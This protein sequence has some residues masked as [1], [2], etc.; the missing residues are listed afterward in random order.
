MGQTEKKKKKGVQ[1]SKS[2]KSVKQKYKP[3]KTFSGVMYIL[4]ILQIITAV[5]FFIYFYEMNMWPVKYLLYVSVA[6]AVVFLIAMILKR[7]KWGC[8]VSLL[9]TIV[10]IVVQC[11]GIYFINITN[12]TIGEITDKANTDTNVIC[13]LVLDENK[14]KTIQD[15]KEYNFGILKDLER[16][17]TDET[18]KKINSEVGTEIETTE[19][20][21]LLNLAAALY[22]KKVDAIIIN[23]AYVEIIQEFE[24]YQNFE[25][26]I[27]SIYANVITERKEPEETKKTETKQFDIT[28]DAFNVYVSGIDVSG[29]VTTKSRSDVNIIMSINPSTKQILLLSTPRDY[30]L[31][32]S[33]SSGVKDKLTH[34][35]LYGVDVSIETLEMLYGIDIDYYVRM[36]FTGFTDIVNI[37]GGIEVY[38]EY[39]FSAKGYHFN[40][41]YNKLYGEAA[42]VFARERKSFAAGDNQRGRNQMEVIKAVIHKAENSSLL[43]NY[44]SILESVSGCMQTDMTAKEISK[45]VKLQLGN[46]VEWNIQSYNVTGSGQSQYTYTVPNARAYVMEP[47]MDTVNEAKRLL[48]RVK[49]GKKLKKA[50]SEE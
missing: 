14:A 45:L 29:D 8:I 34:A 31:P 9:L 43:D 47:N 49:L 35:G 23:N 5:G 44:A 11:A 7:W 4:E 24:G 30:Y 15:A 28:K 10:M 3:N 39:S 22:S 27:R 25:E 38:S 50:D 40:A 42:L 36:N 17:R 20:D 32:L 33:I 2:N 16:E 37:L 1:K 12:D 6:V 21:N 41:G 19:C 18:I 46:N 26:M 48:N 13:V